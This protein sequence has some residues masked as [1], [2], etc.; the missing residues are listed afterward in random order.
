MKLY[1]AIFYTLD[2]FGLEQIKSER[3]INF[4]ADYQAFE[5]KPAKLILREFLKAG[6]GERVFQLEKG[7]SPDRLLKLKSFGMDL[8]Q[9]YG[10]NETHVNY[11]LDSICYALFWIE[12][13]PDDL[14]EGCL[15][16]K[17][18][19]SSQISN[20]VSNQLQKGSDSTQISDYNRGPNPEFDPD[21]ASLN[22]DDIVQCWDL[23]PFVKM[24]GSKM[25]VS[26]YR[27]TRTQKLFN[28]C[29]LKDETIVYF[30]KTLGE[31]TAKQVSLEKDILRVA[32]LKNGRYELFRGEAAFISLFTAKWCRYSLDLIRS[33]QKKGIKYAE[34]D[35]DKQNEISSRYHVPYLPTICIIDTNDK[36]IKKWVGYDED[37]HQ[38]IELE[39]YLKKTKYKVIPHPEGC[40]SDF[41]AFETACHQVELLKAKYG[42]EIGVEDFELLIFCCA[43]QIDF[44]LTEESFLWESQF[45]RIFDI[46][47]NHIFKMKTPDQ[48]WIIANTQTFKVDGTTIDIK[49]N[50]IEGTREYMK[51]YISRRLKFY[52]FLFPY[53]MSDR[54]P[55]YKQTIQNLYEAMHVQYCVYNNITF[56]FMDNPSGFSVFNQEVE[57][58]E[59]YSKPTNGFIAAIKDVVFEAKII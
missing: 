51:D 9:S 28:A 18:N 15:L 38:I 35:V 45:Y 1:E 3:L 13:P 25:S 40:D 20:R 31:L 49:Q 53:L 5:V 22:D 21:T 17:Y 47:F 14:S 55:N 23:I 43:S 4:L 11:V 36:I 7:D 52:S 16:G 44:S 2:R 19:S 6:Y 48:W 30:S 46:I 57:Y 33:L 12:T 34:I 32:K 29:R 59:Q 27:N 58:G 39:E 41:L 26:E 24:H 50:D 42:Q 37:D 54:L 10:F 56:L 8:I